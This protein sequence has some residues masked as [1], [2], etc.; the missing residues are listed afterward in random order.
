MHSEPKYLLPES[1]RRSDGAGPFVEVGEATGKLMVVTLGINDVLE[2]QVLRVSLW[3]SP[4]GSE[5]GTEPLASF[6]PRQYCGVYSTLL[7]LANHPGVRYLRVQ[8]SMHCQGKGDRT[9]RFGF[10]VFLQES[11]A[12]IT[13]AV[14]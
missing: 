6:R 5:F 9:P 4:D 14:A 10:H 2:R 12:R 13:S 8:W 1:I 3:G 7:N 11:G